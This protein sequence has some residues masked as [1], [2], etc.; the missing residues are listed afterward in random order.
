[1]SLELNQ[2]HKR[3]D[4]KSTNRDP[5]PLAPVVYQALDDLSLWPRNRVAKPRP[6]LFSP[7]ACVIPNKSP[8]KS[9]DTMTLLFDMSEKNTDICF[10]KT[11]VNLT[12]IK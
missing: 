8:F 7:Q 1:M 9:L 4:E 5:L 10:L 3:H 12:I 2:K 6:T 11:Q